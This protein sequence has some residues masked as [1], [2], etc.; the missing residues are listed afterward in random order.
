MK[1]PFLFCRA[2]GCDEFE[3]PNHGTINFKVIVPSA[4][5]TTPGGLACS[6]TTAGATGLILSNGTPPGTSQ[7][8][9]YSHVWK[10]QPQRRDRADRSVNR[11]LPE[12]VADNFTEN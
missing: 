7:G 1:I 12:R 9:N 10:Y 11:K 4:S 8:D 6:V 5:G 3:D 2:A